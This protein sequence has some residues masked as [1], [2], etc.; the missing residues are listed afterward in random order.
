ML[1]LRRN[2][3]FPKIAKVSDVYLVK[4]IQN[5]DTNYDQ[6]L[7]EEGESELIKR[8]KVSAYILDWDRFESQI[9]DL[10]IE[11]IPALPPIYENQIRETKFIIPH[12]YLKEIRR[13]SQ[14]ALSEWNIER[15][16]DTSV[17]EHCLKPVISFIESAFYLLSDT[18]YD[19]ET[20]YYSR[21]ISSKLIK[22][23]MLWKFWM[24]QTGR[25]FV[26]YH[27]QIPELE[28]SIEFFGSLETTD[29]STE[30]QEYVINAKQILSSLDEH[31]KL[32]DQISEPLADEKAD[33][34][35]VMSTKWFFTGNQ[36]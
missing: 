2:L 24:Y 7:D 21:G 18:V 3:F 16:F 14:M 23:L 35:T 36:R 12:G 30:Y 31:S 8:K 32:M 5:P 19:E 26:K 33:E 15:G 9:G 22:Y 20:Q 27:A 4:H 29:G 1:S 34:K 13:M 6:E 25:G 10:Y 11:R 17:R 28:E